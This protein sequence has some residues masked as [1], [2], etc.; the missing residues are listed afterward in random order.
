MKKA[1]LTTLFLTVIFTIGWTQKQSNEQKIA[2]YKTTY[3][4]SLKKCIDI[5][6]D[7]IKLDDAAS[8]VKKRDTAKTLQAKAYNAFML[9]QGPDLKFPYEKINS[10]LKINPLFFA[11]G[12]F[13]D[14]RFL[15][16]S[17]KDY[18]AKVEEQIDVI[19]SALP[20]IDKF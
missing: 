19:N 2:K 12:V 6:N 10:V 9:L 17:A 5:A 1:L 3:V 4:N 18:K 11:E 8:I 13:S 14:E 7:I 16:L 20:T 15:K